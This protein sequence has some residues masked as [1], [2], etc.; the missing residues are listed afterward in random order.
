MK[1]K[2]KKVLLFIVLVTLQFGIQYGT[3]EY[4]EMNRYIKNNLYDDFEDFERGLK[5]MN[6]SIAKILIS[7]P[8]EYKKI[9]NDPIISQKI[10]WDFR[11][12]NEYVFDKKDISTQDRY[13][14]ILYNANDY[15]QFALKDD[16]IN[17]EEKKYLNA[18]FLYNK[19]LLRLYKNSNV[20]INNYRKTIKNGYIDFSKKADEIL[21][22]EKYSIL[23][24]YD[25]REQTEK[26]E[27][28]IDLKTAQKITQ[29][30]VDK[31]LPVDVELSFDEKSQDDPTK[32]IFNRIRLREH[33]YYHVEYDKKYNR[34]SINLGSY[35]EDKRVFS[36]EK[37]NKIADEIISKF[38]DD[39]YVKTTKD[40]NELYE[41]KDV[42]EKEYYYI[43]KIG[44]IYDETRNFALRLRQ[45]G[46]V[47]SFY[48]EN[49]LTN[50]N[51]PTPKYNKDEILSKINQKDFI[52]KCILIRNT[53]GKLEYEVQM[54]ING[55]LYSKVFDGDTGEEKYFGR[56]ITLYQDK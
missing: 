8:K 35:L 6:D 46:D 5:N 41:P 54:D 16:D 26:V 34:V 45:N 28:P 31:G 56:T 21:K 12:S 24:S 51:I 10:L 19:E 17:E 18:L 50:E 52:K 11:M 29:E 37:L 20:N 36:E 44:N 4:K 40:I 3:E 33:T 47:H 53:E 23:K 32:Y 43:K 15:I 48:I 38:Y 9:I 27:N 2:L 14:D 39:T 55:V 42:E 25:Q 22:N 1:N 7:N 30:I 49:V 13:I